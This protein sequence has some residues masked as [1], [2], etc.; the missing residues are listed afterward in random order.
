MIDKKQSAEDRNATILI[1]ED[2]KALRDG[3]AMNF[4]RFGYTVLLAKDGEEGMAKAFDA[5]PDLIVL[6]IM[7][8]DWSG[9]DILTELRKRESSVPIMILSARDTISNKIEGL[10]LG[11]DDY[12]TKPFE[13][14]EL[15]A[16]IEAMLRRRKMESNG[17]KNLSFGDMCIQLQERVVTIDGSL[18]D[19]STKEFD[20]LSLFAMAPGRPFTRDYILDRI[21]GWGF[22]GTARTVDNFIMSLRKK[23]EKDPTSPKY[24]KTVRQIGY[25]FEP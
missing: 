14:K 20:L 4:K 15:I 23:I 25:K 3:L 2:D 12:M 8:P 7:L 18:V 1:V 21:W 17:Q 16:R 19:L 6:D 24:I 10:E 5:N 9:L 13:L 11:A 22:E